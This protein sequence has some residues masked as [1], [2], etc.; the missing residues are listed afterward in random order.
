MLNELVDSNIMD[1]KEGKVDEYIVVKMI[2]KKYEDMKQKVEDTGE[3][4]H[5][6][7]PERGDILGMNDV[8]E[9]LADNLMNYVENVNQH[10]VALTKE[11]DKN[12]EHQIEMLLEKEKVMRPYIFNYDNWCIIACCYKDT[13]AKTKNYLA[14]RNSQMKEERKIP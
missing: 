1:N 11:L 4:V 10:N 2:G 12:S 5:Y 3:E 7:E 8:E 6:Y 14:Q 9:R 13:V